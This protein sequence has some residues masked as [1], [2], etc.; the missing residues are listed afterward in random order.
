M[1]ITILANCSRC[2]E[3]F[4]LLAKAGDSVL[5]SRDKGKM[6]FE[7][8][9]KLV[10]HRYVKGIHFDDNGYF[11]DDKSEIV[12]FCR[13]CDEAYWD[14]FRSAVAKL[15]DFWHDPVVEGGQE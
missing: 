11:H 4:V 6:A 15:Q 2:G 1:K 8:N 14:N 3:Q 12:C 7:N 5:P 10:R 9:T 13:V